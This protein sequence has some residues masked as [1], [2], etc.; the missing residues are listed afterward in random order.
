MADGSAITLRNYKDT[1]EYV[2]SSDTEDQIEMQLK[3]QKELNES[4][5]ADNERLT[6]ENER[7][8]AGF[9]AYMKRMDKA[10]EERMKHIKKYR[11]EE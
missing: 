4:L 11:D 2:Q 3:T 5:L 1:G 6:K 10:V 9:D 8:S 7:L